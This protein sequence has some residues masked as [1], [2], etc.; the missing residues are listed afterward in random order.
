MNSYL[1]SWKRNLSK[2]D[3]NIK[4]LDQVGAFFFFYELNPTEKGCKNK[5]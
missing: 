5:I 4:E 2:R 1:L 3:P